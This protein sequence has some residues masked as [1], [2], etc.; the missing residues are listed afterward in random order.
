MYHFKFD[1]L[2]CYFVIVL[3]F[4]MVFSFGF[5]FGNKGFGLGTSF[6]FVGF[7]FFVNI[8]ASGVGIYGLREMVLTFG[9]WFGNL[10]FP[11]SDFVS[12][13]LALDLA[14]L[15][16]CQKKFEEWTIEEL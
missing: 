8:Y 16:K 7:K 2:I 4:K 3:G 9:F 14:S 15:S 11:I 5:R 12:N 13:S 1:I 6:N 10:C